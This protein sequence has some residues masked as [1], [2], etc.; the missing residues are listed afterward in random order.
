MGVSEEEKSSLLL[1]E[2]L[3]CFMEQLELLEAKRATLNSLIEQV[4]KTA[5][6]WLTVSKH[7]NLK[8]H[9]LSA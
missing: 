5:A 1:D 9:V 3:L 8:Q 6:M 7:A 4:A 2:K